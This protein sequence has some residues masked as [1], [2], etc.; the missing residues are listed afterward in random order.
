MPQAFVDSLGV[1]IAVIIDRIEIKI[2]WPSSL[3]LRNETWSQYK[4]SDI[5]K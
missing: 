2:E 4:G 3:E 1:K 5:A